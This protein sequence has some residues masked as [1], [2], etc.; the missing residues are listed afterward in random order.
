MED[1][2]EVWATAQR[3]RPA[4]GYG[5]HEILHMLGGAMSSELWQT[6]TGR[7]SYGPRHAPRRAGGAARVVGARSPRRSGP[8]GKP[9]LARRSGQDGVV[10][11]LAP[12]VAA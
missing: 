9:R 8:A 7:R 4:E 2:P 11:R 3:L 10:G 1:P 12:R 5:R 6:L